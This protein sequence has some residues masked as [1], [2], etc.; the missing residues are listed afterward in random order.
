MHVSKLKHKVEL[1][2]QTGEF[3]GWKIKRAYEICSQKGSKWEEDLEMGRKLVV[4]ECHDLI[5]VM[6][7]LSCEWK[8]VGEGERGRTTKEE[9]ERARVRASA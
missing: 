6:S 5:V 2:R 1:Y 3:F 4:W 7:M 9:I 8:I